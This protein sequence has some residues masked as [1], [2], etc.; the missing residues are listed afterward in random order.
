MAIEG[1]INS[2]S[3]EWLFLCRAVLLSVFLCFLDS[4]AVPFLSDPGSLAANHHPLTH[5]ELRHQFPEGFFWARSD[6][7]A[8]AADIE[9]NAVWR[10]SPSS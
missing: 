6:R 2:G 1:K 10:G 5:T 4:V 3:G 9:K 7:I 8:H